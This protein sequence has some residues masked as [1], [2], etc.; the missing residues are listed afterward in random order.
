MDR[1][2]KKIFQKIGQNP[3]IQKDSSVSIFCIQRGIGY[4]IQDNAISFNDYALEFVKIYKLNSRLKILTIKRDNE[5]MF[6]VLGV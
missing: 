2:Y 6:L 3:Q 4:N 5:A 1:V